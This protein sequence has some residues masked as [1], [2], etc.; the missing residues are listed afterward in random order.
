MINDVVDGA[1]PILIGVGTAFLA[2]LGAALGEIV[3]S[4]AKCSFIAML[5]LVPH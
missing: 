4:R 5:V 2:M 1:M 3:G